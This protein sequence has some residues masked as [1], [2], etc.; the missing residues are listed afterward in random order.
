MSVV[1]RPEHVLVETEPSPELLFPEARRRRR[2]RRLLFGGLVS[3]AANSCDRARLRRGPRRQ[4]ASIAS[5]RRV[6]RQQPPGATSTTAGVTPIRPGPLAVGRNG[7]LYMADEAR[8]QILVR[9]RD[10]TFSVLVGTGKVGFAGDGGPATKAEIDGPQGMAV[11]LNG[12]LYFADYGNGR[13]R[14]VTPEGRIHTVA[15]EGRGFWVADGTPGLDALLTPNAVAFSPSGVLYVSDQDEVLRLNG[16]GTF[17]RVLGVRSGTALGPFVNGSSALDTS[18]EDADGIAFDAN[19]D[20]FVASFDDKILLMVSP[21]GTVSYRLG[22]VG[23]LYPRGDGGLVTTA[24]GSVLAMDPLSVVRLSPI[25]A[26]TVFT[27]P[28]FKQKLLGIHGFSPDGIA[29][30]RDGSIY[31]DTF[32]GNG[33]S[34]ASALIELQT[35]GS[36]RLL[37][38]AA[39]SGTGGA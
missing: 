1:E 25:G 38:R 12:T 2:R 35:K 28:P 16:D 5:R 29:V 20:L 31:L 3:L 39:A 30:A 19:G 4:P 18:A 26:T 14:A 22:V 27:T 32:Y 10:G 33:Y 8:N 15:G 7:D 34:S 9:H 13:V 6:P 17:T 37:W 11:A 24:S 21:A 23:A 36:P